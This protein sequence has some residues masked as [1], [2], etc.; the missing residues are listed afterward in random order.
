MTFQNGDMTVD[1]PLSYT[2]GYGLDTPSNTV[3][4]DDRHSRA[5]RSRVDDGN[6]SRSLLHSRL[7]NFVS[8]VGEV[9]PDDDGLILHSVGG[10]LVQGLPAQYD[11]HYVPRRNSGYHIS[12]N[13]EE[14]QWFQYPD[15]SNIP[16][17]AEPSYRVRRTPIWTISF[18]HHYY[19]NGAPDINETA[20]DRANSGSYTLFN[21][22]TFSANQLV[23]AAPSMEQMLAG[24]TSIWTARF[25]YYYR[26]DGW[27]EQRRL[28]DG[29]VEQTDMYTRAALPSVP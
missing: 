7:D 15:G 26:R 1:A 16:T 2:R 3:V 4:R 29:T 19:Q 23:Y 18:I 25:T 21:L 20:V 12:A 5:R 24:N 6:F 8:L 11:A 10:T 28:A 9:H 27:I 14:H 17:D 13:I 22:G